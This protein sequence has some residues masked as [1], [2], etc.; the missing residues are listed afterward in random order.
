MVREEIRDK[1][2]LH[3]LLVAGTLAIVGAVIGWGLRSTDNASELGAARSLLQSSALVLIGALME[4]IVGMAGRPRSSLAWQGQPRGRDGQCHVE[5]IESAC[6]G[7]AS[8]PAYAQSPSLPWDVQA[9]SP[10]CAPSASLPWDVQAPSPVCDEA[11]PSPACGVA[12]ASRTP[13]G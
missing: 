8:S 7:L 5:V 1:E 12:V 3:A 6:G 10:S 2:W 4:A 13:S 9:P 11:L